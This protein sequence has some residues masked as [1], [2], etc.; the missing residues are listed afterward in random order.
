MHKN[1]NLILKEN[2]MLEHS[3]KTSCYVDFQQ[4]IV[5]SPTLRASYIKTPEFVV[6][7]KNGVTLEE[8]VD[9]FL[10]CWSVCLYHN[11]E[12]VIVGFEAKR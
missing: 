1:L 6:H 5:D 8:L 10:Y 2:L 4:F 12:E 11:V 3:F 9:T 7:F